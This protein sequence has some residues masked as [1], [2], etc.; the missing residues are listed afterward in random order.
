MRRSGIC[1]QGHL[2]G[3]FAAALAIMSSPLDSASAAEMTARQVTELF[4]KAEGRGTIDLSKKDLTFLDLS[5]I[6]FKGA[7]LE[8]ADLHGAILSDSNLQGAN[9]KGARLNLATVTRA[10][11]TGANLEGA[12]ILKAAFT[13]SLEP[14]PR[15]TPL[16]AG[17]NLRNARIYSRFDYTDFTGADMSG[18]Y[19]GP[20]DRKGELQL[21]T[22]RPILDG[23]NLSRVKLTNAVIRYTQMRFVRLVDADLSNADL[24]GTDLSRADL[25]G[26]DVTGVNFTQANLYGTVLTGVRGLDAAK[27]LDHAIDFDKAIR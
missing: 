15:E 19:F 5:G 9:L 2:L 6:N 18:A 22:L 16:F 11:F 8:G 17:A 26:A 3:V 1:V 14:S 7:S 24:T 10:N 12:S 4:F 13:G 23:A 21:L 27:G 25:T 20:E